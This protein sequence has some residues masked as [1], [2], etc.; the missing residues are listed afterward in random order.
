MPDSSVY[1]LTGVELV[2]KFLLY[3][4]HGLH[5]LARNKNKVHALT[6]SASVISGYSSGSTHISALF[7]AAAFFSTTALMSCWTGSRSRGSA[8]KILLR[9]VDL[10]PTAV[11]L[12][13]F[14]NAVATLLKAGSKTASSFG[15]HCKQ[16]AQHGSPHLTR[17]SIPFRIEFDISPSLDLVDLSK[18]G[19]RCVDVE[20]K[21][22]LSP[23]L[24]LFALAAL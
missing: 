15:V 2:V 13:K 24:H 14:E 12:S 7:P 19:V 4:H 20:M 18:L 17:D 5:K 16:L 1:L 9:R 23:R 8:K 11:G 6:P 10:N 21:S 3:Q 22:K